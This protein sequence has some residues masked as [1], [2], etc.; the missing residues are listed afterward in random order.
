[1]PPVARLNTPSVLPLRSLT[2]LIGPSASTATAQSM[3]PFAITTRTGRSFLTFDCTITLA[4]TS[5][6]SAL[7]ATICW[8][9]RGDPRANPA[10]QPDRSTVFH[11]P[12]LLPAG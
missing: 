9:D 2:D 7:P 3:T 8:I 5:A 1:M 12:L 11:E 10:D 4:L 6:N